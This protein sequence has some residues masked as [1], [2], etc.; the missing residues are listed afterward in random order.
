MMKNENKLLL[1]G[2]TVRPRLKHVERQKKALR[3]EERGSTAV[4]SLKRR[5][6]MDLR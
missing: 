6:D 5:K 4:P 3:Q 1:L 2:A